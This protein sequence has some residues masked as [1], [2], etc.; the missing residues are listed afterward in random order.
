MYTAAVKLAI[1]NYYKG[2]HVS[3]V[4]KVN[5]FCEHI[6]TVLTLFSVR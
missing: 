2:L 6:Y 5:L 1:Y 4:Y 3:T